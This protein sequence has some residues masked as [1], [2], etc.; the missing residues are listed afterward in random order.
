M[1]E[2]IKGHFQVNY[3][4]KPLIISIKVVYGFVNSGLYRDT[5]ITFANVL[6]PAELV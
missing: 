4:G 2:K 3:D 1:I 6:C 5:F